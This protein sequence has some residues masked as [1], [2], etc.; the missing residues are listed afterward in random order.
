ML[1][2]TTQDTSAETWR[3]IME[4]AN[5]DLTIDALSRL[6]GIA[7]TNSLKSNYKKQAKQIRVSILQAREYFSAAESS[8]VITSPNHLYY[9][10]VS[11]AAAIMLLCGDGEKALDKLRRTPGNRH[12]GLDFSTNVSAS[13]CGQDLKI[14]RESQVVVR[15]DGFF[16]NWYRTLSDIAL[17][18]A[19]TVTPPMTTRGTVGHEKLLSPTN[20]AGTKRSVLDLVSHLP[21][22][23][24]DL[25]QYGV[26]IAV[27]R[28]N[29]KVTK[30]DPTKLN[31]TY[32][33]RIHGAA[34]PDHLQD[35]LAAFRAPTRFA[36]AFTTTATESSK[37]CLVTFAVA[38]AD[39]MFSWPSIREDLNNDQ[40]IYGDNLNTHEIVD[41]YLATYALSMLSRYFPDIWIECIDSH[42]KAASLIQR[43]I[44]V[45]LR[46]FPVMALAALAHDDV[47]ISTHKPPWHL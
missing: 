5:T 32:E 35:I 2:V 27:S 16:L 10:M 13:T 39:T 22:L 1:W 30:P 7:G 11:L 12:H 18:Y 28:T 44:S 26:Q 42:C 47:V 33:W 6:H 3:R 9:G 20:I 45:L 40:F 37:S 34:T 25:G 15:R 24:T 14:F 41:A 17:Q 43:L 23:Y 46:K 8:S 31:A 4:F 21:D 38:D 29:M 19:I 36:S